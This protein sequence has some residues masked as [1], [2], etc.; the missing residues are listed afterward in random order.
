MSVNIFIK[1]Y[2]RN[3]FHLFLIALLQYTNMWCFKFFTVKLV[4]LSTNT[5]F[6]I[7]LS[8]STDIL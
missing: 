8:D 7:D 6:K 1:K 4:L 3:R 5:L 2:L